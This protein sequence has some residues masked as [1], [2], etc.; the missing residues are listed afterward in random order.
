MYGFVW[1]FGNDGIYQFAVINGQAEAVYMAMM[2]NYEEVYFKVTTNAGQTMLRPTDFDIEDSM[3][4]FWVYDYDLE[5]API[6]E[7]YVEQLENNN[8]CANREY[9]E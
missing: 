4:E 9:Y 6:K 3:A 5:N 7:E 8:E 2:L 1:S